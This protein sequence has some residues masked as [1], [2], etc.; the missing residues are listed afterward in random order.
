MGDA[1]GEIFG[2]VGEVNGG[3]DSVGAGID[4]GGVGG[5]V[6]SNG[7]TADAA[8]GSDIE[9][10]GF[11]VIF[12]TGAILTVDAPPVPAPADCC[13]SG[14]AADKGDEVFGA[15]GAGIGLS[16]IQMF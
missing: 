7:L 9:T 10:D 1:I 8:G 5:G 4:D 11:I 6:G 12:P 3:V 2:G 13:E 14:V 16:V 15:M